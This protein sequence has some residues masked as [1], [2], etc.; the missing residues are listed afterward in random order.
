MGEGKH[1]GRW[2]GYRVERLS[3]E[4]SEGTAESIAK[5]EALGAFGHLNLISTAAGILLPSL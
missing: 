1:S 2:Q 5:I 3:E 4:P